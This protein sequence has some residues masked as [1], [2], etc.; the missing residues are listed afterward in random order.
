MNSKG[1]LCVSLAKSLMRIAGVIASL[2]TGEWFWLAVLL[3]AA[4][5]LGVLEEL[6]DRR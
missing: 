6:V 4:E 5:V 3:G 1:H 2:Y